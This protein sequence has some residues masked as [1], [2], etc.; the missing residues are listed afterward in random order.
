MVKTHVNPCQSAAS[1][2]HYEQRVAI[3]L[4]NWNAWADCVD[5][6]DS[7][8]GGVQ[9]PWHV[10]LVDNASADGSLD[11]IAAWCA[12]PTRP[13]NATD[14]PG[15]LR[16]SESA[17]P[18]SLHVRRVSSPAQ[19]APALER[20]CRISLVQS[21]SN[22]GFAGGNNVGIKLGLA[23]GAP[24]FWL[25]N[26]DTVVHQDALAS[27]LERAATAGPR[28]GII[29]STLLYYDKPETVQALG[30]ASLSHRTFGATHLGIGLRVGEVPDDPAAV[31]SRMAYVVGASMLVSRAFVER[32][33]LMQEDYFLYFEELDWATR[34]SGLF[35]QHWAPR[36]RVWHKVGSSS[37]KV[38]SAFSARLLL[39]N[40]LRFVE[41]FFPAQLGAVRRQVWWELLRHLL[42]RRFAQ[43]RIYWGVLLAKT[44]GWLPHK[45]A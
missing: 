40:R 3:V 20:G 36:S 41:R 22:L 25:L 44:D 34:A 33:G 37:A 38:L 15:V 10:Y 13:Q 23:E 26:T 7:L 42:K 1:S 45:G 31:E 6:L 14:F 11:K 24:W 19:G 28:A 35:T 9:P 18:T 21:G 43:A 4:V 12:K 5:C 29:G 39:R 27:L 8:F 32:V 17:S 30:G 16:H 2:D